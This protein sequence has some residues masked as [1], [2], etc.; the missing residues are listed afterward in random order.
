GNLRSSMFKVETKYGQDGSPEE[1]IFYGGGW[2]HGV[3]MC[4]AGACGMAKAG[5]AYKDILLHYFPR[6]GLKKIY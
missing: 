5:K 3:G 6:A 2:G 1:F 4:Q